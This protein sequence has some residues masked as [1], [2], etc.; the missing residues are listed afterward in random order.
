MKPWLHLRCD[1]TRAHICISLQPYPQDLASSLHEM[2]MEHV[3]L[4]GYDQERMEEGAGM[5]IVN[6]W[7]D[8]PLRVLSS[9]S[10]DLWNSGLL[11]SLLQSVLIAI[12]R[13]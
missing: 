11:A 3:L 10:A 9:S 6:S 1:Y 2:T 13:I 5:L 4:T 12:L 7:S 8:R